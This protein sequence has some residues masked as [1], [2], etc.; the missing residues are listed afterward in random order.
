ME[1]PWL[2]HYGAGVPANGSYPNITLPQLVTDS[3]RRFPDRPALEFY[4]RCLTYRELEHLIQRFA[5]ALIELGVQKGDRVAVMLPNVPQ[6][7]IA[8]FGALKAGACVVQTN[9]LYVQREIT[10]QL[11]DSGAETIVTL[12]Q[13]YPQIQ[14]A[15]PE[16]SLKRVILANVRDYLPWLKRLLY[17]LKAWR[18]GQ[19]IKIERVPPI[20]DFG[21]LLNSVRPGS[22]A[23]EVSPDDLAL[24]QY[25]G[26]TTGVPKG[27]MLTHRNLVANALQCRYWLSGLEEGREVFLGVL[28]FFHVYGMSTCQ[29]L[30]LMLGAKIV[31]L[32]KFQA[33]E[34]LKAIVGHRVTAFPGIPA[35]YLALNNHPKVHEYDLSSVR[36]CISG[37]G[38]LFA[39]VQARFEK[40]TGSSLVEG[41]G[42][43]EASPVTHCNPIGGERRARSIGVPISD[44]EA[45]LVDLET[46]VRVSEPGKVGE[47]RIKGPQ[48]MQGYWSKDAE[49]AT[50][51]QDGWLCTG[52]LASMD[53]DGFFYIQDRLKDMIKS[54]GMNVYP[55]EVDECLCQHPKVKEA[56][57]IGIPQELRGERIKAFI[58]LKDGERATAAELLG[59]CRERLAKFKVPKQIEFR[60]ELPKTLVGKV[61][62]RVLLE[63]EL[64]RPKNAADVFVTDPDNVG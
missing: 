20:Y 28:P 54:G 47:L 34:V 16:T 27:A 22:V 46:G 15:M 8:Y 1:R 55:R 25:T 60:K 9:P 11:N 51:F 6:A 59:Y 3:A 53:Q 52:D 40:L 41:Y 49:T 33:D 43:T 56:C 58:V 4:G 30:A 45:Q 42:L 37:A 61:L 13:F 35:M 63:E 50:V 14:A 62:R 38:P 18:H 44:T 64:K 10:H 39:D 29:N 12:D 7:L 31:L 24:L 26:G 48:V 36:F 21:T 23:R 5:A 17:P 32:P 19:S 57:V 2:K